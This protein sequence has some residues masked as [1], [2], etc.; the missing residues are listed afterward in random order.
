M[1]NLEPEQKGLDI[2]YTNAVKCYNDW[3]AILEENVPKASELIFSY[4]NKI[5][6]T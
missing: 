4:C 1:F 5:I 3:K 6:Q 2:N